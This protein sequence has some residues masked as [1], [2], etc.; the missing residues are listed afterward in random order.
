MCPGRKLAWES[1][2]ETVGLDITGLGE[3]LA[4]RSDGRS[5][6]P[7][8]V[9]AEEADYRHRPLL[10]GGKARQGYRAAKQGNEA[11]TVHSVLMQPTA[12]NLAQRETATLADDG[13]TIED[14]V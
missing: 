12:R 2:D 4:E 9:T 11:P 13:C 7:W 10:C 6:C 5:I 8:R 14:T 3:S 1:K